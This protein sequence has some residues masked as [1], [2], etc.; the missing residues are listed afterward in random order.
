LAQLPTNNH[1][2][3]LVPGGVTFIKIEAEQILFVR[4]LLIPNSEYVGYKHKLIASGNGFIKDDDHNYGAEEILDDE[5]K[6]SFIQ[7]TERSAN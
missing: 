4:E 7:Y 3:Y 5:I 2:L 6:T 1:G